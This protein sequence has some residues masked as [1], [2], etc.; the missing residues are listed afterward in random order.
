MIFSNFFDVMWNLKNGMKNSSAFSKSVW[1][2][3]FVAKNSTRVFGKNLL[4]FTEMRP[5]H[6]AANGNQC[7]AERQLCGL[8]GSPK[9]KNVV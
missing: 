9:I 5:V 1:N 3:I 8:G 4:H 2:F 6:A 7:G